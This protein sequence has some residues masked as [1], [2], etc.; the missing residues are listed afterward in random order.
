[1][2]THTHTCAPASAP[3]SGKSDF[4]GCFILGAA[5][6]SSPFSVGRWGNRLQISNATVGAVT[7]LH[8]RTHTQTRVCALTIFFSCLYTFETIASQLTKMRSAGGS[9]DRPA[10]VTRTWRRGFISTRNKVAESAAVIEESILWSDN[11][12]GA[13]WADPFNGLHDSEGNQKPPQK[14]ASTSPAAV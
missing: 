4:K 3:L 5:S 10:K 1:M 9:L 14:A 8:H 6:G 2:H 11:L 12:A 13:L 7:H